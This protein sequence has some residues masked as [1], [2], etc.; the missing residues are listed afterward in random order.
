[1]NFFLHYQYSS[2]YFLTNLKE[3]R[4]SETVFFL[5]FCRKFSVGYSKR[6]AIRTSCLLCKSWVHAEKSVGHSTVS[7]MFYETPSLPSVHYK[8]RVQHIAL[9]G[10][11]HPHMAGLQLHNHTSCKTQVSSQ[12]LKAQS[13]HWIKAEFVHKQLEMTLSVTILINLFK[14]HIP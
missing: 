6:E 1:M 11:F 10:V 2:I 4:F 8:Y 5:R 3:I 12:P 13:N 7:T 9:P 14:L